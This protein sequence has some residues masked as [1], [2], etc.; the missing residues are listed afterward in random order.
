MSYCHTNACAVR[1]PST[2]ENKYSN[3]F[4]KTTGPT[5]LKFHMEH[6]L[7]PGS[8]NY[9]IGSV[10]ISKMAT[11]T[12]IAKLTKSTSSPEKLDILGCIMAWNI[13]GNIDI[14]V[15]GGGGG[16]GE[17]TYIIHLYCL[18]VQAGFNSDV[19]EC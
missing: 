1:R 4:C 5:V 19:V 11:V 12:K 6:D 13:N 3:I 7:T 8:Q 16:G 9:K 10:R 2:L 17:V 14:Y 18:A 15:T